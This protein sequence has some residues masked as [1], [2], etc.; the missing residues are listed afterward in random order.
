MT[1]TISAPERET[2]FRDGVK[3]GLPFVLP[4]AVL[5]ISFGVLAE[6]LMG[7]VAPIVMSIVVFAGGAQ[8]AALSVLG[9]GAGAGAAIAG[10]LLMNSRFLPMGFALGPSLRGNRVE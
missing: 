3:A 4:T 5:A 2:T 10:G 9:A 8:F 1:T 6:P 7:K